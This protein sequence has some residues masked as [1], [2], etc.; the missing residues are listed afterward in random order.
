MFFALEELSSEIRHQ[1]HIP[2]ALP[3]TERERERERDRE[4]ETLMTL[5]RGYGIR[6]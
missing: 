5:L 1:Y 6:F 2:S 4:R 3:H